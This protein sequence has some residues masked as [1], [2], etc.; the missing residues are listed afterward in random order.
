MSARLG[1]KLHDL[2][3][4]AAVLE[5]RGCSSFLRVESKI[6]NKVTIRDLKYGC[7]IA[8]I[9]SFSP[10]QKTP[11]HR[12]RR[13]EQRLEKA[14]QKWVGTTIRGMRVLNLFDPREQGY[15]AR[16]FY[17][18][19]L[20]TCGHTVSAS[21]A[22][23]QNHK[24]TE[25]CRTCVR[26]KHGHR[27]RDLEGNRKKRTRT[28]IYWQYRNKDLPVEFQNDY[29][30]FFNAV[31]ERPKG[32]SELVAIP[33]DNGA[34]AYTWVENLLS[35]GDEIDLILKS[36]RSA[37]RYSR[38]YQE[39]LNKAAVETDTTTLYECA[40]C[41]QLFKRDEVEVDHVE[42]VRP[43][44]GSDVT[45]DN[46]ISRVWT[47]KLQVLDKKCHRLKTHKD[48]QERRHARKTKAIR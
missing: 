42:S 27:A 33:G 48:N 12:L 21:I 25:I 47:N 13:A 29:S 23:L 28:Y 43:V 14:R 20:A 24:K 31:G 39:C 32:K 3:T 15:K 30:K 4:L 18:E 6:N 36:L 46:A 8:D 17:A 40:S 16:G 2:E 7:Y 35:T 11:L 45:M 10:S 22:T 34:V 26:I 9:K 37:F 5:Q 41:K 1:K 19:C 44:D 38:L